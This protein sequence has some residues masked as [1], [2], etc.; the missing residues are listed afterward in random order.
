MKLHLLYQR[1]KTIPQLDPC[2]KKDIVILL[3]MFTHSFTGFASDT[4]DSEC[5]VF[6]NPLKCRVKWLCEHVQLKVSV[7]TQV[8]TQTCIYFKV[9]ALCCIF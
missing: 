7:Y 4:A 2:P 6:N 8:F 3:Y 5:I 9:N 1:K